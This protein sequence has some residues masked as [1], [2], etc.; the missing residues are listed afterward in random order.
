MCQVP[1]AAAEICQTCCRLSGAGT[2]NSNE[3]HTITDSGPGP[4]SD[5][6]LCVWSATPPSPIV[7]SFH[8]LLLFTC[9]AALQIIQLW[10][11]N[12][13]VRV[14]NKFG[15]QIQVSAVY[16]HVCLWLPLGV[17]VWEWGVA[18]ACTLHWNSGRHFQKKRSYPLQNNSWHYFPYL[19]GLPGVVCYLF[20]FTFSALDICSYYHN[21][22][23]NVYSC[24][25]FIIDW[26]YNDIKWGAA[27]GKWFR[28]QKVMW[29]D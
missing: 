7:I 19:L 29:T 3:S 11:S 26:H 5:S 20:F 17:W 18:G 28:K 24:G 2:F 22:V 4:H 12:F 15:V 9:R 10:L 21:Y 16:S 1:H 14:R 8:P 27:M 23:L 13:D 25:L 6:Q